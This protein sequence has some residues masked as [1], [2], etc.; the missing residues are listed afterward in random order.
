MLVLRPL[1][2][3]SPELVNNMSDPNEAIMF[4]TS[5]G[6]TPTGIRICWKPVVLYNP[7][8]T[9]MLVDPHAYKPVVDNT[10]PCV[11]LDELVAS[12]ANNGDPV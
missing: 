3:T 11:A 1:T 5:E 4:L 7:V 12:V 2:Y 9:A 8:P 10:N 6:V